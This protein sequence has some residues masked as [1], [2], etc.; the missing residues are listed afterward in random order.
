MRGF[1]DVALLVLD[2]AM[3][4]SETAHGSMIPTLRASTAPR[5]PQLGYAGSA[6][7]QESQITASCGRA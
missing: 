1:D 2:E 3:I 5:G 7:D 4:I 6:V